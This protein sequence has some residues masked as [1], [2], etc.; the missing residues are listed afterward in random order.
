MLTAIALALATI[1]LP[2]LSVR[3]QVAPGISRALVRHTFDEASATWA[4]SAIRLS[5]SLVGEDDATRL[6]ATIDLTID[7]DPPTELGGQRQLG[8][9]TFDEN[10]H[11]GHR[12]HLS[13]SNA[14]L[15]L[16]DRVGAEAE[17]MPL[18]ERDR[19]LGRALG[20]ALAHELGH[21]LLGSKVHASA[22]LMK[23]GRSADDFFWGQVDLFVLDAE[24]RTL[25]ASRLPVLA[26]VTAST[27]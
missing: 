11:P 6:G 4:T 7:N 10:N 5:L 12:I 18:E 1:A 26:M 24:A 17:R 22:G 8:W 3:L 9:I 15:L 16:R 20:R 14:W 2:S 25:I 27:R 23:A 13:F 19:L 21:Y